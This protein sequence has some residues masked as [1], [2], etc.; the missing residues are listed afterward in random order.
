MDAEELAPGA[1]PPLI[2]AD[3][4]ARLRALPELAAVSET[5]Y[6]KPH[7]RGRPIVVVGRTI[8][9]TSERANLPFLEPSREALSRA[10][11]EGKIAVSTAFASAFGIEIG[12]R[13]ELDS[14]RGP[15]RLEIGG[16]S[17]E[18][19]G[20]AGTI[21]M[22]LTTLE[23]AWPRA[24]ATAVL[25]WPA[26]SLEEA[27]RAIRN[28]SA[29]TDG[30]LVFEAS[31]L[32]ENLSR[33][34]ARFRGVFFGMLAVSAL[35]AGLSIASML[36]GIVLERGGDVS[37]LR[38]VGAT[39]PALVGVLVLDGALIGGLGSL[40]GLALGLWVTPPL[41]ALIWEQ[42]G[43]FVLP[44]LRWLPLLLACVAMTIGCALAAVHP[45][46]SSARTPPRR[47]A[48]RG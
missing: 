44:H 30:I 38:A 32:E 3:L 36:T 47:A 34:Y 7:Y 10:L 2:P 16:L 45:G 17:W 13:I 31:Q 18:F 20:P 1:G 23:R 28:A 33:F 43:W 5:Y 46:W 6:F 22:D 12:D 42:L 21:E 15:Q 11:L 26:G 27:E 8:S 39:R 40:G 37:L 4:V 19:S 25:A 9:V 14:P 35:L 48:L 29:G 41:R 24:G